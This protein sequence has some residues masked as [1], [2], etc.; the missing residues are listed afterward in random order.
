MLVSMASSRLL[1]ERKIFTQITIIADGPVCVWQL[2]RTRKSQYWSISTVDDEILLGRLQTEFGD[3]EVPMTWLQVYL[4]D[5]TQ[6]VRIGQLPWQLEVGVPRGSVLRSIL[7][8]VYATSV[9]DVTASQYVPYQQYADDTRLALRCAP[10]THPPDCQSA[11][12]AD[13]KQWRVW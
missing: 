4:D 3:E 2:M 6:Y 7:F 1:M 9:A 10:T 5:S 8:A 12:T 13:V 11:C